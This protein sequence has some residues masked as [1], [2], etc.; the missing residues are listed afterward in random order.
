L[1]KKDNDE[2]GR[3]ENRELQSYL[4][5]YFHTFLIDLSICRARRKILAVTNISGCFGVIAL[6]SKSPDT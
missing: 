6:Y 5:D 2:K 3:F 4:K 1:Q